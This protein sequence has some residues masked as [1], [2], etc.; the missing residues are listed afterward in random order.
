[1][2]ECFIVVN[3][4]AEQTE[5]RLL[6]LVVKEHGFL[7]VHNLIYEYVFDL[8][9]VEKAYGKVKGEKEESESEFI[10]TFAN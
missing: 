7:K 3:E 6:G 10:N 4:S 1:M 2:Q 8:D 5:L 9:W